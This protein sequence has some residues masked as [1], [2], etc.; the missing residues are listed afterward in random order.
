MYSTE[1]Q[2]GVDNGGITGESVLREYEPIDE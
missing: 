1:H 2:S